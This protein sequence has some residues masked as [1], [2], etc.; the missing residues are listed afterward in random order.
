MIEG[1]QLKDVEAKD[2][3]LVAAQLKLI[4]TD[5]SLARVLLIDGVS[6]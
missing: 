2:Y 1:L 6:L 4:G 5:A 3:L